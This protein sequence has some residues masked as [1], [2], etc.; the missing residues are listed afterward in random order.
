MMAADGAASAAPRAN[1]WTALIDDIVA[2]R[3]FNPE[4]NKVM[5]VDYESIVFEESLDGAEADLVAPLKLGD[6]LA[7]VADAATYDALGGR[8]AKRLKPLGS[9][10]TVVLDHPHADLE[11]VDAL[12]AQLKPFDAVIAV[13]SGTI[14]DLCK[15]ATHL[16]GRG[17]CVFGTAASM[18][19]YTSSTASM[20]LPSGLKVSLP[21]QAPRGFFVDLS[22]SA[23]A[24]SYLAAAGFADCLARSVAQVD[25]W[26]SHRLL[27]TDYW[28]SPYLIQEED[29][30]ILN[31]KAGLL[32]EGD[33]A[34]MGSLYRVLTLCGLGIAF[35][36]VS[37]HGSM[38][39]HQ[40]SHYID[41]F[42][43]E[44]HPGTLH[45]QQVGVASLTMARLQQQILASD[46]PPEIRPTEI[47]LDDMARRMGPTIAAE[48]KAEWEK[49][50]FDAK[51][52]DAFNERLASL[53]PVLKEEL[54]PF[55]IP[56]DEIDAMLQAAGG[57][58]SAKDLGL[59]IEFYRE[60][61]R[62]NHEMRNRFSFVDVASDAGLLE[63]FAAREG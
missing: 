33:I 29:E 47:D 37:N 32:P 36:G 18:N 46:T 15:Y 44:Q 27:G 17:Y 38:G 51:G 23:Q 10:D 9:V 22:V 12:R 25:W 62:H 34:A 43:R 58:R 49:K 1:N 24:P 3:W 50:A 57:P 28:S 39:E 26:M 35:T 53:W 20:N 40:I 60:A 61:V 14:N 7:V 31:A 8:V 30:R 5:T 19:G 48:C 21:A 11:T 52:A 42:A 54:A 6:T 2:D 16:D 63:D 59:P 55:I 56:V 4:L 13:G 41:C 45:G